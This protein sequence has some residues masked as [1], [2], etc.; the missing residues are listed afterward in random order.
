MGNTATLFPLIPDI[1]LT[2]PPH[3][4]ISH[5]TAVKKLAYLLLS[6]ATLS[7]GTVACSN[8]NAPQPTPTQGPKDYQ[9]EYRVTSTT[10]ASADYVAYANETGATTTLATTALPKTFTFKRN[11][12]LGDN[13]SLVATIPGGTASSE[14]TT[15]ILLDGKEVKK[16]SG[17]GVD[18]R[19][20]TV[21]VIGE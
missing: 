10:D 5:S 19:A 11:M 1:L 21:Y 17:R 18:A 6:C 2:F 8:D 4:H 16:A 7:L 9:V 14:V 12:K 13:L 15:T 20:I 3:Y